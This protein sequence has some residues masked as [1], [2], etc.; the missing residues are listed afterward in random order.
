VKKSWLLLGLALG[1]TAAAQAQS[2]IGEVYSGEASVHGA[3]VLSGHGTRV[4]NGS[5]VAA[6]DGAA[7]LKLERGGEVRICPQTNLSL[8]ADASGRALMLGLNAGSMELNYRLS[9]AADSVITPDFRLQLISPG[10]FHLAISVAPSGDTCVRTLAENEAAV[11]ITEMMSNELYQLSPEKGVLFRKGK[12]AGATEAPALCGC[13]E[14]KPSVPQA[15]AEP[16]QARPAAKDLTAAAKN[17][18]ESPAHLEVESS[19][20]FRGDRAVQ[21][22]YMTVA[23]LSVS[24]DNS[25]LA[26]ALLPKVSEPPKA[27]EK[28]ESVLHRLASFLGKLFRK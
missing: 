6:G 20:A 25:K 21:D 2:S 10:R 9:T 8:S 17:A 14:T 12:I 5:Q 19:M 1:C 13:P 16:T 4:L 27:A 18:N 3:V 22:F 28:K 11:F 7:V 26:L 23:K 24:T 15:A